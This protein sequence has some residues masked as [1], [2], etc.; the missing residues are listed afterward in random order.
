MAEAT[1]QRTLQSV[2]LSYVMLTTR[3][4]RRISLSNQKLIAIS[5]W[6]RHD[7]Q[8]A[9]YMFEASPTWMLPWE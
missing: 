4:T 5:C 8:L 7:H 2:L 3:V 9:I 1:N 6:W